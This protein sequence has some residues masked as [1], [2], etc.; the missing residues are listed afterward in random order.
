MSDLPS[1]WQTGGWGVTAGALGMC[2][3]GM[4]ERGS[5]P[6]SDVLLG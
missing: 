3:L 1:V 4:A 6:G 5:I 2:S